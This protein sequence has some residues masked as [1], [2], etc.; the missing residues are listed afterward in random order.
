MTQRRHHTDILIAGLILIGVLMWTTGLVRAVFDT[1]DEPVRAVTWF[2][3]AFVAA[4]LARRALVDLD[5]SE[6]AITAVMTILIVFGIHS[7]RTGE[8]LEID[9][10]A[11]IG[12]AVAGALAGGWLTKKREGAYR[13]VLLLAAGFASLGAGVLLVGLSMLASVD[14]NVY[15][16]A[17]LFGVVI[18]AVLVACFTIV[19][20]IE[21]TIGTALVLSILF[22]WVPNMTWIGGL[23]F[24]LIGG[25]I[26]GALGGWIGGKLRARR[27]TDPAKLPQARLSD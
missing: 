8:P 14:K 26:L 22:A 12:I 4:A 5:F 2:G 19:T 18:G 10:L 20:T 23:L 21:C 16:A 1:F 25:A 15:G 11:W 27:T 13:P 17:L 9:L 6:L 3:A 7:H 24:G